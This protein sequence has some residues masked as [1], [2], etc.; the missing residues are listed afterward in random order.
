[1]SWIIQFWGMNRRV[2]NVSWVALKLDMSKAYDKVEWSFLEH[3]MLKLGFASEWVKLIMW[4]I[5]SVSYSFNLN[6]NRLGHI[7]PS[8]GIRPG[9]PL[10]LYLFLVCAEGLS[11]LLQGAERRRTISELSVARYCPPISYLFFTDN[12]LLFFKVRMAEGA[13]IQA[14]LQ[15]Y[16][17]A[18]GQTINFDK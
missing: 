18:S 1:M 15:W 6:G 14:A 2:G 4:C 5:S 10:S 12:S 3:I 16:E 17:R 11:C 9:D 7:V 13:A 8:H